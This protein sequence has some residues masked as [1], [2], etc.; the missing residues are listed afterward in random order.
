M[1][2]RPESSLDLQPWIKGGQRKNRWDDDNDR[3]CK[4]PTSVP[5]PALARVP[6]AGAG[7]GAAV[8]PVLVSVVAVVVA[9]VV[10][11]VPVPVP[12]RVDNYLHPSD[13]NLNSI[14][15]SFRSI[16]LM[17]SIGVWLDR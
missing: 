4:L 12:A 8:V 16:R 5:A 13:S 11:V 10:V 6:V 15:G 9:V 17:R 7:A 1:S 14:D 2:G 3:A